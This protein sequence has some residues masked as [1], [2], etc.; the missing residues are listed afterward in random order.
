MGWRSIGS[1]SSARTHEG[2]I[3]DRQPRFAVSGQD[4]ENEERTRTTTPPSQKQQLQQFASVPN[5]P[6]PPDIAKAIKTIWHMRGS[7]RLPHPVV[8]VSIRVAEHFT[9]TP[10]GRIQVGT[11]DTTRGETGRWTTCG[12]GEGTV[13]TCGR[14]T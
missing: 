2:W 13:E 14:R 4:T 7:A 12:C 10:T 9:S 8:T 5:I 11:A 6:I 3:R 1:I